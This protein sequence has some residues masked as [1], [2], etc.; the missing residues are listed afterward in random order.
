MIHESKAL[1]ENIRSEFTAVVHALSKNTP[2][3]M[4]VVRRNGSTAHIYNTTQER[5]E[6]ESNEIQGRQAEQTL[7]RES[8]LSSRTLM[9]SQTW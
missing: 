8:R 6:R 4:T 1:M 2:D 3:K 5:T 7:R 9:K